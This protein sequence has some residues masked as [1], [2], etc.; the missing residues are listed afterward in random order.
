VLER[1]LDLRKRI[2][3]VSLKWKL[4]I[5]F[6][7]FAFAGTS[8]LTTI[9]LASQHRLIKEEERKGLRLY[10][11]RFLEEFK[12]KGNQA[13]SLAAVIA[14]NRQVQLYLSDKDRQALIKLLMPIYVQLKMDFDIAQVHLHLPEA[15]S[16]L[17][18]HFLEAFGDDLSGYRQTIMD[19]LANRKDRGRA[20]KGGHGFWDPRRGAR[21][22]L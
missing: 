16:F 21:V 6:L 11:Q 7:F 8:I 13:M 12:E 2:R 20:R 15:V 17:R 4:L 10:F 18:L 3:D 1:I 5:P 9:N 22:P 14:E 19:A